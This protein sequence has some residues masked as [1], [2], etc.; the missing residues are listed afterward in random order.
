MT[1]DLSLWDVQPLSTLGECIRGV[2]YNPEIHLSERDT[3]SSVRLLRS[4][5]VQ[6]TRVNI[7]SIQFVDKRCVS[8]QQEMKDGD[9]LIC[10]ANGSRA[11]VGK[12]G[13]FLVPTN[14]TYTFGAFM[15]VFRPRN[16]KD[17][18]YFLFLTQT[19]KF[20]NYLDIAL[21]GSSI[22][23]LRPSDILE[24]QFPIP[25]ERER[26][27][28]SSVLRDID[29]L[30][31]EIDNLILK[32]L[33]IREAAMQRLLTGITRLPGFS[34]VWRESSLAELGHVYGGLFGKSK[35]DFGSGTSRFIP[36]VNVMAN[37]RIDPNFLEMV[38]IAP[39]E[40]QNAVT[41]GDLI[42][43]GS[44]ETP[45][46][47]GLASV[48]DF[49]TDNIYL[50]SFCFGFH[51]NDLKQVDPVFMAYLFRGQVGRRIMKSLAQ[52]S[53]RYNLSK[54][55]LLKATFRLP[56]FLEQK[57]IAEVLSDMDAEVK[58]LVKRRD[59]TVLIK[60]GMLQ[61]LLTGRVRL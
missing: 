3:N 14:H 10:M 44:S 33:D 32:K 24:M 49:H 31:V 38:S 28:I 42:F 58:A 60:S 5:N 47:V 17:S 26:E 52:G 41:F 27:T 36:F 51:P 45:E 6:E 61:N 11:L 46:E 29:D 43:N 53:T 12:A 59:K 55:K 20:R 16:L 19:K 4:N 39:G 57:A 23:N 18:D 8:P 40:S 13:K 25:G 54:P 50:N 21:S 22:N 9:I 30:V 15:G 56:D 35:K 37:L 2:T 34:G 1:V 7:D 48:V